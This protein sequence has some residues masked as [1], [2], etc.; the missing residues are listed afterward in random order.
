VAETASLDHKVAVILDGVANIHR[1]R[2][3]HPAARETLY[4]AER[5]AD[6][7]GDRRAIGSVQHG[8]LA[9]EHV[10]GNLDQ[11]LVHGWKAVKTYP[12]HRDQVEALASL[13]GALIDAGET[14]AAE[15]AWLIV[16]RLSA[17][18]YYRLFALEALAYMAALRGD[19]AVFARRAAASDAQNW[20]QGPAMA[21]A[22]ILLHRGRALGALGLVDEA[23]TWLQ[24]ATSF[25]EENGFGRSVF[26]AEEALR[27]LEPG[28]DDTR[29]EETASSP[30]PATLEVRSGLRRMR[31]DLVEALV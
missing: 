19:R 31:E 23:R 20:E 24:R 29:V 17:D 26:A 18:D 22:E 10:A 12:G 3:N 6:R 7:S 30:S 27:A 11:A 14:R 16:A 13:A 2:G 9:L 4:E 28:L 1:D 21:K 8:L 25:A 5:F 15:D